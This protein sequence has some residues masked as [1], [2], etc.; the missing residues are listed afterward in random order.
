MYIPALYNELQLYKHVKTLKQTDRM[1][2]RQICM[3]IDRQNERETDKQTGTDNSD[4]SG[5]VIQQILKGNCTCSCS[6][7]MYT[8]WYLKMCCRD[9]CNMTVSLKIYMYMYM[10][11]YINICI[12]IILFLYFLIKTN[13]N[14]K[15]IVNAVTV[16][17]VN[18]LK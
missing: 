2:E 1:R 7:Y 8:V 3:K 14:M 17:T 18:L 5:E 4:M 12:L 9:T 15:Y 16:L 6:C 10:C 11:S 13:F